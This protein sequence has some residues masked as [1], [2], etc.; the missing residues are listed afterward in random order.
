MRGFYDGFLVGGPRHDTWFSDL[1]EALPVR[2]KV[3]RVAA[4]PPPAAGADAPGA[5][6]GMVYY[7][8][9][10]APRKF[11]SKYDD[12]YLDVL[13]NALRSVPPAVDAWCLFD[14][15]AS[16]AALENAHELSD[17]LG[18]VPS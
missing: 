14:N 13:G 18:K 10:G 9:H 8:L 11:W 7:R 5:W 6:P 17:V 1:A 16:G 2:F 15:T 12:R 4:D 3:A